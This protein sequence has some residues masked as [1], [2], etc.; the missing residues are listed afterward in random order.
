[1]ASIS[2]KNITEGA[3]N[4]ALLN[5]S[6][7]AFS[8]SPTYLLKSSGPFTAKKFSLDSVAMAF[9]IMVLEQPGGPYNKIPLEGAIPIL[10]KASG[11]FKGHSITFF[12]YYLTI[13]FLIKNLHYRKCLKNINIKAKHQWITV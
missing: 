5:T 8:E 7:T 10:T 4:L 11:C 6:L 1:M 9:A 3:H 12:T 2:S 13:K